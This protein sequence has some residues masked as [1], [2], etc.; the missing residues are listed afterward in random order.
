MRSSF[1]SHVLNFLA[2][3][4]AL[5]V[6][7]GLAPAP[8]TTGPLT[9]SDTK[10]ATKVCDVTKYGAVADGVTDFGPALLAAFEACSSGGVVNIPS[11]TF[12]MA[13]WQT[14]SGGSAWAI[15]LEG[16]IIRTGTA[17]GHMIVGTFALNAPNRRQTDM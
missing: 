6:S 11:G 5:L 14:L 3:A 7:A 2:V 17:G 1:L 15:N 12:A 9:S 4:P 16:T 8:Y 10:W 13:T